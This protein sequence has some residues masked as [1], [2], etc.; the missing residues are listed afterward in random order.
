MAVVADAAD[1]A[2]AQWL[3]AGVAV[4]AADGAESLGWVARAAG[5]WDC[6]GSPVTARDALAG[7]DLQARA[8]CRSS[9]RMYGHDG[10]IHCSQSRWPAASAYPTK[11]T[12]SISACAMISGHSLPVRNH[13]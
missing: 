12:A 6:G 13:T 9:Q 3:G 4:V 10:H 7:R 1:D 2:G 11:A 5:S 8:G